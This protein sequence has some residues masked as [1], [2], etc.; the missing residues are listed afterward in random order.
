MSGTQVADEPTAVLNEVSNAVIVEDEV[1][2]SV[3][4][5][6]D[7]SSLADFNASADTSIYND[8]TCSGSEPETTVSVTDKG[9][10]VDIED[11]CLKDSDDVA[12]TPNRE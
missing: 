10:L 2:R 3:S 7:L 12:T 11:Y 6:Y 1:L 8:T 9:G 5:S 4:L